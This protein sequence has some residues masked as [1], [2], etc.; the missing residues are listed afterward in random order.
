MK[1]RITHTV[2]ID[3]AKWAQ[4][5]GVAATAQSVRSDVQSYFAQQIDYQMESLNLGATTP[6]PPG[7]PLT[8]FRGSTA[9]IA[10]LVPE[11]GGEAAVLA[12]LGW[13]RERQHVE[14]GDPVYWIP[15]YN[16]SIRYV[17]ARAIERAIWENRAAFR[18]LRQ[19]VRDSQTPLTA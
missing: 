18:K 8:P 11:L 15:P 3:P 14:D 1:V 7:E 5:F 17:Q 19:Q 9:E 4:E 6:P 12:H 13:K 2:D 10:R 16:H